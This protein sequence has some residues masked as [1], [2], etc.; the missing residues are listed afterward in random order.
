[1]VFERKY[2]RTD[3]KIGEIADVTGDG[4]Q[5][6][7]NPSYYVNKVRMQ[8]LKSEISLNDNSGTYIDAPPE[9]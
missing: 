9:E 6:N 8:R 7:T 2:V 3:K 5:N 1:M 4:Y